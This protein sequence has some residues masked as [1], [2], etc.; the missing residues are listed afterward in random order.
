MEIITITY[1]EYCEETNDPQER[2]TCKI[3]GPRYRDEDGYFRVPRTGFT[4]NG[5]E[6]RLRGFGKLD[7]KP[8]PKVEIPDE[9]T[10]WISKRLGHAYVPHFIRDRDLRVKVATAI[11]MLGWEV[12]RSAVEHNATHMPIVKAL[13]TAAGSRPE[14]RQDNP[15]DLPPAGAMEINPEDLEDLL[16]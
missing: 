15:Y 4:R 6:Y 12:F 10:E 7:K 2:R 5:V 8:L 3:D 14:P 9:A 16:Q 13:S 1:E 11:R